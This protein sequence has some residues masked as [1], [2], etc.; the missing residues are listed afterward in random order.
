MSR[1]ARAIGFACAALA[2]AGLAATAAGGYRTGIEGELG[3]LEPVVVA[4][5][6]LPA[7]RAISPDVARKTLE[8]RRI[9]MRFA[10]PGA[11]TSPEAAIGSEP[12][13][14]LPAGAY[15]LA[16]QLQP[17]SRRARPSRPSLG[18]GREPVDIEVT[19]ADALAAEGRVPALARVDVVVTTEAGPGRTGRTYVAAEGVHLLSLDV[20]GDGGGGYSGAE[21]QTATLALTRSQALRLIQAENFARQVRLIAHA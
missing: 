7:K 6:A 9:P 17:P 20:G 2:C 18:A 16:G 10:P 21:T 8:V 11:V 14:R 19:G 12:T 3:P 5:T 1:R 4:R 13:S 15:L